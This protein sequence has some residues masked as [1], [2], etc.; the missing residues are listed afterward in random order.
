M[1]KTSSILV[2]LGLFLAAFLFGCE[3][4]DS[5][6]VDQK[7][8]QGFTARTYYD[9]NQNIDVI[10]AKSGNSTIVAVPKETISRRDQ[11]GDDEYSCLKACKDIEDLEK[12]LN[13]IL[14]CPASKYQVYIFR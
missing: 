11:M 13:C 3:K 2:G 7:E 6:G 1:L 12:R 8:V 14:A 9:K 5:V 4:S 10:I